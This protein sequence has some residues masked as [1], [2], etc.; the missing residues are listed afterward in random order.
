M[1]MYDI[2]CRMY[3]NVTSTT[4][5]YIHELTHTSY[6]YNV[7]HGILTYATYER[8][9]MLSVTQCSEQTL[10]D[11]YILSTAG[12]DNK[13]RIK[14]WFILLSYA[15]ITSHSIAIFA[16]CYSSQP[17]KR[18]QNMPVQRA[19]TTTFI[20]QVK[21]LI[22]RIELIS[23]DASSQSK[24]NRLWGFW[25]GSNWIP[26]AQNAETANADAMTTSPLWRIITTI[27]Q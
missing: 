18:T 3:N 22:S 6:L 7:Q 14:E 4:I 5:Y 23:T 27:L 1:K 20:R 19:L 2:Q 10:F 9:C 13:W 12:N 24:E 11:I 21:A 26:A 16:C 25:F 8:V 17:P 15:V